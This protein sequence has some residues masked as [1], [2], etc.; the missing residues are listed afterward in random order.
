MLADSVICDVLF[1]VQLRRV[2]GGSVEVYFA[3]GILGLQ[4]VSCA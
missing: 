1:R 3:C 4:S 2:L